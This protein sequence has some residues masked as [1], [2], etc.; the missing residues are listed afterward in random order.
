MNRQFNSEKE[1]Q[2]EYCKGC[3]QIC[4]VILKDGET[5]E[6]RQED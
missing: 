4:N 2:E 6:D 3:N 1:S 5:C